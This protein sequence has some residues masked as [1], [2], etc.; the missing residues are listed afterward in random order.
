MASPAGASIMLHLLLNIALEM[1]AKSKNLQDSGGVR[2]HA[3]ACICRD[4]HA[5]LYVYTG[6]VV[7]TV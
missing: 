2:V 7:L 3:Y 6:I 4:I 5:N 1:K